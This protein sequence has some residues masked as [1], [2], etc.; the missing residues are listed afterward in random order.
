MA[1][2][3]VEVKIEEG[4]AEPE[5]DREPEEVAAL[6]EAYHVDR[7]FAPAAA[8]WS[9]L[10]SM[11]YEPQESAL[12]AAISW[13]ALGEIEEGVRWLR[14][15]RRSGTPPGDLLYVIAQQQWATGRLKR[16]LRT[17]ELA[18]RLAG[19][20]GPETTLLGVYAHRLH[21][22]DRAGRLFA[23][24]A[25]AGDACALA[26]SV[27]LAGDAAAPEVALSALARAATGEPQRFEPYVLAARLAR[28]C[29]SL[30]PPALFL[31]RARLRRDGVV[32]LAPRRPAA[33]TELAV[34][35]RG[36]VSPDGIRASVV[37]RAGDRTP[38]PERFR[39]NRGFR[40]VRVFGAA[41]E[42][43]GH[44]PRGEAAIYAVPASAGGGA[45]E[46]TIEIDGVPLP[47]GA[48]FSA[49][50]VE[51][52][53]IAEWLPAPEPPVR[54]RWD[55]ELTAPPAM[56]LATSVH[57]AGVTAIAMRRPATLELGE[58]RIVGRR[59][60]AELRLSAQLVA[61]G[62]AEWRAL[63]PGVV[64]PA[65][66]VAV[67]D[68]PRSQFCY[69]RAGLVR[70]TNGAL[71]G[72]S[73]AQLVHKASHLLWGNEVRFADDARWLAESLA[74]YGMHLACES[75]ALPDY[76][77]QTLAALRTLDGGTLC[78]TGLATLAAI[79]NKPA[80]FRLRAKGGFVIAA[81]R[82]AMGEDAFRALLYAVAAAGR[83]EPVDSYLFFALASRKNGASL[84]WFA[85][86]WVYESCELILAAH[87]PVAV[88]SEDG[89]WQLSFRAACEGVAVPGAPVCYLVS[90]AGGAAVRLNVDLNLG[91]RQ[92]TCTLGERPVSIHPDPD[93]CWYASTSICA[94]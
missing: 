55:V 88:S 17:L 56:T 18:R 19:R 6:A 21:D 20:A 22:R 74:D 10:A 70:V 64:Q 58:L 34:R 50:E 36:F 91:A 13:L 69:A 29:G 45:R 92:V 43:A 81:L 31:A 54:I 89:R 38:L 8:A 68:R 35:V 42:P 94:I 26:N 77:R 15:A 24:A 84:N 73:A 33:E 47:P 83:R 63:L 72:R 4:I 48:R 39:L 1:A 65:A 27:S 12:K 40:E 85:R 61:R 3:L 32:P 60:A 59:P 44:D 87:E 57:P 66:T 11:E 23:E 16:A 76:R 5:A 28:T 79:R 86:Q 52:D 62:L 7:A 51:L 49:E 2:P 25:A 71:N 80:A 82:A 93:A 41:V 14:R 37:W 46:V 30:G 75:G 53:A 9:A 78:A 90:L 67:V